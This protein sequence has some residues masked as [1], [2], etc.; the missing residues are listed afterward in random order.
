MGSKFTVGILTVKVEF[1]LNR[2]INSAIWD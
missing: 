1:Y 2:N